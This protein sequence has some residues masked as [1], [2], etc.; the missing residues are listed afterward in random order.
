MGFP[1][2]QAATAKTWDQLC[3]FVVVDQLWVNGAVEDIWWLKTVELRFQKISPICILSNFK[4]R[5]VSIQSWVYRASYLK[6]NT[7]GWDVCIFRKETIRWDI[8]K[9]SWYSHQLLAVMHQFLPTTK[10]HREQDY[11]QY[12]DVRLSLNAPTG[13]VFRS[14]LAS[15][16][17]IMQKLFTLNAKLELSWINYLKHI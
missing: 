5:K 7:G 6:H 14:I 11:S 1:T 15:N 17:I 4:I 12:S 9:K 16:C 10:K 13:R 3:C 2:Y 8:L